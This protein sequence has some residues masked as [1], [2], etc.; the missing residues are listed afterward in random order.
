MKFRCPKCRNVI[1][2]G[3]GKKARKQGAEL[4]EG[5]R[6]GCDPTYRQAVADQLGVPESTISGR[7]R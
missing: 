1:S 2:Q 4:L 7:R 5:H 6:R 3:S